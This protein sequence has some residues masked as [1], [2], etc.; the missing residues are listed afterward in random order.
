[1]ENKYKEFLYDKWDWL[2]GKIKLLFRKI[3]KSWKNYHLTKVIILLV[4]SIAL[5]LSVFFT[6]QAR[7]V[8]IAALR[9]GIEN[10]TSVFD[11][12]Q[13]L[14]GNIYAQKGNFR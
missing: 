9:S 10:P 8:N 5:S 3:R 4:L 6:I 14:A 2:K 7:R 13:E 1:M 11:Y 12:E